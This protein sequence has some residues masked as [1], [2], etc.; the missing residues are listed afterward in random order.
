MT[1]DDQKQQFSFAFA[2]A[3]A[4][5]ARVAVNEPSVD[6]DS[7]D[8]SFRKRGGGGPVRSPQLDAQLKC[9]ESANIHANH[10]AYPLKLK[11]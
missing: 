3:V 4:A 10:I 11:N 6:D 2:R 5:V 1:L 9:T 7:V 8:L